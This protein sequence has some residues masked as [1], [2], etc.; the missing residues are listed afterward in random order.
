MR[1]R[2]AEQRWP[3][4]FRQSSHDLRWK[5]QQ[6]AFSEHGVGERLAGELAALIGVD[7]FGLPIFREGFFQRGD[8]VFGFQRDLHPMRQHAAACPVDHRSQ[9]DEA[10]CRA[11]RPRCCARSSGCAAGTARSCGPRVCDSCSACDTALRRPCVSL[12]CSRAC[13]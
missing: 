10:P 11:P 8:R 2:R 4:L 6:D 12:T 13:A 3:R 5:R 7:D 1:L 9:K